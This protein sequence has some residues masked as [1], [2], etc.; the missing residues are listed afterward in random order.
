MHLPQLYP[1]GGIM[2]EQ[3][4]QDLLDA[5]DMAIA[6]IPKERQAVAWKLA[7]AKESVFEAMKDLQK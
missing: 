7:R 3:D 6:V 5:L 1:S 4:L 2:N